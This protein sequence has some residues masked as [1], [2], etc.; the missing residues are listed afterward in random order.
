MGVDAKIC[1]VTRDKVT[2]EVLLNLG[3][4]IKERFWKDE[5]P[6]RPS[7]YEFEGIEDRERMI[8]IDSMCRIYAIGYERGSFHYLSCLCDFLLLYYP[9]SRVYYGCDHNDDGP[10]WTDDFR[11]KLWNHFVKYGHDPYTAYFKDIQNDL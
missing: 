4:V 10:E 11:S 9:E 5:S 6:S 2:E 3:R 8:V 1:V 7:E